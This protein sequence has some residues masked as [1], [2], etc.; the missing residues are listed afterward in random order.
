MRTLVFGHDQAVAHWVFRQIGMRLAAPYRAIGIISPRMPADHALVGGVVLNGYNGA[1]VDITLYGPGCF[2]RSFCRELSMHV[3]ERLQCTRA[4]ART[5][6][7][8]AA[9]KNLLPRLGFRYEG[10]QRRYYGSRKADDAVVFG[11]LKADCPW[12]APGRGIANVAD[13]GRADAINFSE[14]A[15]LHA[16][17]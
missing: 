9:M 2:S 1:N 7:D 3:F 12:L 13:G 11:M 4:T 17:S 8:N 6:R 5:R 15:A 14:H 16:S 10:T